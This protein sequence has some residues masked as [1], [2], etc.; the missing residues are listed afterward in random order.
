MALAQGV[1]AGLQG[2]VAELHLDRH[3]AGRAGG[4]AQHG[5]HRLG[6]AQHVAL[7]LGGVH[8]VLAEGLFVPDRLGRTVRVS[9]GWGP[10]PWP[11]RPD[12][13]RS[14]FRAGAPVSRPEWRP[15]RPRCARRARGG[16]SPWPGPTPQSASTWWP[17]RKANSTAGSM[18]DHAGP[19]HESGPADAGLRRPGGQF[20]DHFGAT[21]AHGAVQGQ[22]GPHPVPQTA[23]RSS[24][25]ARAYGSPR[26][27]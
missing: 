14:P 19:G 4:A 26:R 3:R 10:P 5:R 23:G 22:V 8:Q 2:Q 1:R 15:G 13:G 11:A 27:H 17:C 18:S 24:R 7:E 16:V 25:D 21:D 6:H 20:G 12:G 9:P